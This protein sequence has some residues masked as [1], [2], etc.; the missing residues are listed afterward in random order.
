MLARRSEEAGVLQSI[1]SAF[2]KFSP[3]A[4]K[5]Q[6]CPPLVKAQ[7]VKVTETRLVDLS[8]HPFSNALRA[9]RRYRAFLDRLPLPD[10]PFPAHPATRAVFH[11]FVVAVRLQRASATTSKLLKEHRR[12]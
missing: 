7:V 11:A 9:W 8:F 10:P 12:K 6:T 5:W 4:Q 1:I 3:K 2:P